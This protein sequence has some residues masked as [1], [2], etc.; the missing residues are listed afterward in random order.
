MRTT[1]ETAGEDEGDGDGLRG[2]PA[3]V[4][5]EG[6]SGAIMAWQRVDTRFAEQKECLLISRWAITTVRLSVFVFD[7]TITK[8]IT[9]NK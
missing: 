2:S 1:V 9:Y 3:N 5:T 4:P 6:I 8:T 7:T